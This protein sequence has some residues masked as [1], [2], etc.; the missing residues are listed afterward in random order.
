MQCPQWSI[1]F[2]QCP[3]SNVRFLP[4]FL[5]QPP[6][7]VLLWTQMMTTMDK[8]DETFYSI[9]IIFKPQLSLSLC[10]VSKARFRSQSHSQLFKSGGANNNIFTISLSVLFPK[11]RNSGIPW[12]PRYPHH[13]SIY[14]AGSLQC[15]CQTRHHNSK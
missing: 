6:K 3:S 7:K 15:C 9:Q 13:P 10:W 11:P 2:F 4:C 12:H 14:G 1:Y 8:I 5:S